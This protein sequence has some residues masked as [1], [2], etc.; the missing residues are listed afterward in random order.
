MANT[1]P[2]MINLQHPLI[3]RAYTAFKIHNKIP[4][5]FPLSDAER[6]RF[7]KLCMTMFAA[8]N[9]ELWVAQYSEIITQPL[10]VGS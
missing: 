2:Y 8:G 4:A 9:F 1:N 6:Y 7:E 10:T 3:E 5:Q